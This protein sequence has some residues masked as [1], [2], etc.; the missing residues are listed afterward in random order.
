MF[1]LRNHPGVLVLETLLLPL[2]SGK[3]GERRV[4]FSELIATL[5]G[6]GGTPLGGCA[7][8]DPVFSAPRYWMSSLLRTPLTLCS[9]SFPS[10]KM[11]ASPAPLKQKVNMT[12]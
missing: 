5:S 4:A 8:S 6:V 10:W 12:P 11:T 3:G 7:G 2:R 1:Y 9:C